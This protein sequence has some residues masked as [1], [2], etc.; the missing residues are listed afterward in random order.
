MTSHRYQTHQPSIFK[1]HKYVSIPLLCDQD[2]QGETGLPNKSNNFQHLKLEFETPQ[3]LIIS[4]DCCSA[5]NFFRIV[6]VSY[7]CGVEGCSVIYVVDL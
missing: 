7:P 6:F 4:Q 3:G 5:P 1:V 2:Q